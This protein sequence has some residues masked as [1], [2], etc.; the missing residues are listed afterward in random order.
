MAAIANALR[1]W[2]ILLIIVCVLAALIAIAAVVVRLV[3]AQML[4]Y[5]HADPDTHEAL[6]ADPSVEHLSIAGEDGTLS[7]Y[8][9][10]GAEDPSPLVLYFG[11]NGEN[12]ARTVRKLTQDEA[13]RAPFAGCHFAQIDYPGYGLS[14]GKPSAAS[15][16]RAALAAYDALAARGDVTEILILGYSIGT[17]PANYCAA[18]RPAAAL[19]LM[20]PYADGVDLYNN[21]INVFHGPLRL[22]VSY[23]MESVVYASDVTVEP[24]IFAT[25]A[26]ALVPWASS[27]RLSETYPAG[28]RFITVPDITHEDF[29]RTPMVLEEITRCVT[30]AT[31][32]R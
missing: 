6:L 26:D 2:K 8:L 9:L 4:F 11:G 3:S 20:A 28:C 15:L 32:E 1:P 23:D 25:E 12:A 19:I 24:L 22:L 10:R 30:A 21:V 7:G 29:W 5:P 16:R 14:E 13:R 17:G 27:K 18:N 31:Q